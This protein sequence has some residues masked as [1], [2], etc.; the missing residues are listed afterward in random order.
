VIASEDTHHSSAMPKKFTRK[1]SAGDEYEADGGFVEDAPKSK[2]TKAAG[3]VKAANS[4]GNTKSDDSEPQYWEV[5][6]VRSR[7]CKSHD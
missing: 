5:R 6:R 2:K 1:R 3:N 4:K 7:Q